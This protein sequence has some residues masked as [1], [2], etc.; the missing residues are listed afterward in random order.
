MK[1]ENKYLILAVALLCLAQSV[2]AQK[3][4]EGDNV[5]VVKSFDAQLLE[6]NKL[7][8]P[9]TLPALDTT[10]KVQNYTVPPHPSNIK[11]DPPKLRPLGMK[12]APKESDY[13][14]FVKLGAGVP[15]TLWGEGGYYF[16]AK[17]KFD[18]KVWLRHHRLSAD[19]AV[20]NQ[21]FQKT[22][23]LLSGNIFLPNNL[24]TQVDVGYT[25]DRIHF[26][27]YDHDSLEF[28]PGKT[29]QD[30]KIL[31][32]GARLYN[33]ARND[34]DLN[35]SVA[36]KFYLLN[37]FY[38]NKETNFE[39][40]LSATKWFNEKHALRVNIRPDITNFEDTVE[41][42]LNNIYLQPSFTL[43]FDFLQFKIGGNF[44]N[45]RDVFS[46]FPDAELTLRVWGDGIQ[47]FVGA[48]GDL[49]KNTYR[50]LLTYN[51]FIQ[52]RGSELKNTR[53]DNYYGGVKG[54]FGWLEYNG[55]VGYSKASNLA[56][57][58]TRFEPDGIT[59]FGVVYDTVK[60]FN[61]QG[62]I[63]FS[64]MKNL[65]I[66]GTY[67]QSVF[68]NETTGTAADEL[69]VWGLPEIE[70]NFGAVYTLA[71][72]KAN[73]KASLHMADRIAFLNENNVLVKSKTLVDLSLGG[74]YYFTKNI[75]VFLDINNLLNNRRERWYRYPTIGTNFMGGFVARF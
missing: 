45:N 4:L 44:V 75:G 64:P 2:N 16:N 17:E 57:H 30:Y 67:S 66:S 7:S 43:H 24:A 41:Q 33:S 35:F 68:D 38:S 20:E 46:I 26:Y 53:W 13:N 14:G 11:Y 5:T 36:P 70:G 54:N 47:A 37:D 19:K 32:L 63:K 12:A 3:D 60:I 22:Q 61:I 73:V 31:D 27:G 69:A 62:T 28:S 21:M 48:N 55:Q 34:A 71:E 9:P 23:G 59:R 58:Q 51:P 18:A 15:N 1:L 6:A 72:G 40:G 49:R 25:Y 10:T 52:I 29:R 74:S 42:K 65:T 50:S 39:L 56:L 8:V